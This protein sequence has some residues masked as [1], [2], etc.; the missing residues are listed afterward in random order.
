[1]CSTRRVLPQPVGPLSMIGSFCSKAALKRSNSLATG[2]YK[3]AAIRHATSTLAARSGTSNQ[4]L[5]LVGDG[6]AYD[7]GY[8]DRYARQDTRRALAEASA[9]GVGCLGVRIGPGSSS[10]VFDEIWSGWPS[11]ELADADDLARVIRP[12]MTA[13]LLQART[14]R[15]PARMNRTDT[16]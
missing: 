11:H 16:R 4:L 12:A 15:R 10:D 6:F 14:A 5:V 8:E 1:M 7:D 3:G 9:T 13:A 2:R